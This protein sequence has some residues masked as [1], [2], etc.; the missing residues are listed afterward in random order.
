[1]VGLNP[2]SVGSSNKLVNCGTKANNK[3]AIVVS[4]IANAIHEKA[5]R[6]NLFSLTIVALSILSMLVFLK[7]VFISYLILTYKFT[8][9]I[10]YIKVKN[11]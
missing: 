8:Y 3:D 7:F 9:K 10:A 6:N 11:I 4:T 5:A 1:M 2:N